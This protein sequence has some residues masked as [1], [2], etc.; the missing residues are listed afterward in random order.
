MAAP[1]THV[2]IG[3][4]V[5]AHG[6]RGEVSVFPLTEEDARLAAGATVYLSPTPKGDEGLTPGTVVS[7][8]RHKGRFLLT[9]EGIGDRS[10]AKASAG[11]YLLIPYEDAAQARGEGEFF[12]HELVG[13]EV[14]DESGE[15]LGVVADVL[16]TAGPP[17]IEIEG[18]GRARR[19]LPFVSQFIRSVEPDLLVV[20]PPEGWGEI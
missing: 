3:R 15:R 10:A 19:M 18:P 6:I 4:I 13:R 5:Q 7:S 11:L 8:R 12:L 17:V 14:R 2:A 1:P 16:E 20:R 9:L